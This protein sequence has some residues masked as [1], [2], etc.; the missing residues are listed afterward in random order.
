MVCGELDGLLVQGGQESL[1]KGDFGHDGALEGCVK[2]IVFGEESQCRT[3]RRR[4]CRS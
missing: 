2:R 3:V 1:C 4:Y